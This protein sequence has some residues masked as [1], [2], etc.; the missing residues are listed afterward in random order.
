[1]ENTEIKR[2]QSELISEIEAAKDLK[3]LNEIRVKALGKAGA[4]TALSKGMRDLPAEERP[5]F[6]AQINQLRG[7]VEESLQNKLNAL[8]QENLLRQLEEEK[9]D[10]T[11]PA[12]D[13]KLGS[14]HPIPDVIDRLTDIC[15]DMGFSVV[16]GPEIESDYYNFEAMNIPKN[17]PSRDMQDT[18]FF[19]DEILLRSQT[20]AVQAR[21]METRKPPFKIVCPGKT[22][23]NDSDATHS[24][25][26][27]QMEGLVVDENISMADLK[28]MLTILMRRLFGEDTTIRFRPSF[29]PFTEPSIEVDVSCPSCHGKGCSTC[30]GT[31]MLEL[32]GAGI[33]NPKVLEMSGIDSK[34]YRGFAFGFGLDRTSMILNGINNIRN[35]YR[36]DVRF[37]EQM[38]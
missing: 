33:V 11:E 23:R 30:K 9:V 24:P 25:V 27:H 1:M 8:E 34:K 19:T 5:V 16:E 20:S 32:L 37:L 4:I 13:N 18:F 21:E 29:F 14:V 38:K 36:N 12:K 22:Y 15:V 35:L 28:S 10:I 3:T 31:G 2:L 6:G 17:H 7:A 26:F